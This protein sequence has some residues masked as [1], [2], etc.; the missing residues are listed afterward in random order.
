M[1][2]EL[3]LDIFPAALRWQVSETSLNSDRVPFIL[4]MLWQVSCESILELNDRFKEQVAGM[5][6]INS[7]LVTLP[8]LVIDID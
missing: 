1:V 6:F 7:G 3:I 8:V 5:S 2:A 4:N